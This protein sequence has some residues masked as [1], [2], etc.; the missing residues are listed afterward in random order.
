MS[1]IRTKIT[2]HEKKQKNTAHKQEKYQSVETNPKMRVNGISRQRHYN[3]YV[4]VIL[5]LFHML[6]NIE[7]KHK[8]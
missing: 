1:D 4:T 2:R 8:H 5:N 7:E 3:S 6:R